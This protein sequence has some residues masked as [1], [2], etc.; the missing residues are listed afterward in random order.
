[1]SA[2]R[3]NYKLFRE[4]MPL[5]RRF[6]YFNKL[7]CDT[8]YGKT[9]RIFDLEDYIRQRGEE[10]RREYLNL[11][12]HIVRNEESRGFFQGISGAG[13]EV[14]IMAVLAFQVYAGRTTT[15]GFT[16]ILNAAKRLSSSLRQ[17]FTGL[18]ALYRNDKY[19]TDFF[20]FLERP[21]RLREREKLLPSGIEPPKLPTE[22]GRIELRNVSFT[23]PGTEHQIIK[24]VSLT[25]EPGERLM[26]VGENGAGK[27]T[28]VKLMMRL[29]DATEGE[30][31][32]NGINIKD[33]EYDSYMKHFSEVFQDFH[34]FDISVYENI[35]FGDSVDGEKRLRG[36]ELLQ[37]TG[38]KERVHSMVNRG[39]TI[40]TRR[41]EEGGTNLSLGQ[42]QMLA[43]ARS[44][45][46]NGGTIVMDEPTASLSSLAESRLYQKFQELSQGKTAIFVSHRL[47]SSSFC[48]RICVLAGGQVAE[49]GTHRELMEQGGIYADMY[50]LQAQ[51]Y[52]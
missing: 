15:G 18:V 40:L 48:D 10:N 2:Q 32:Y 44:V 34:I 45:Y 17:L 29:Y 25:I 43:F 14:G 50:R 41:L 23:Y 6:R 36:D 49:Y 9:M 5:E 28:L 37:H 1:M 35:L 4:Q 47:S 11:F 38:L 30:I 16:M 13:I 21:S 20:V 24:N 8:E 52:V 46:K 51:Y 7:A 3:K 31:L 42:Q 19:I 39:D 26:I 12:R 27:T 33:Y 22:P